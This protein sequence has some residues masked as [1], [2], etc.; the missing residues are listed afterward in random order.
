MR[1]SSKSISHIVVSVNM[2]CENSPLLFRISA[3][4]I[5]EFKLEFTSIIMFDSLVSTEDSHSLFNFSTSDLLWSY[6]VS[7][8]VTCCHH[9][10]DCL[11]LRETPHF[12]CH[13]P[14]CA[15]FN[16]Y[17]HEIMTHIGNLKKF[18]QILKRLIF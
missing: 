1:I 3:C 11:N 12:H 7:P 2:K 16:Y 10:L 14:P 15:S 17:P 4:D 5:A 13:C 6:F 9:L 18:I 8:A